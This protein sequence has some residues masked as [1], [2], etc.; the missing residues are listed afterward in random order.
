MLPFWAV[1][2]VMDKTGAG[3][4]ALAVFASPLP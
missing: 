1:A 4:A 2:A 3:G